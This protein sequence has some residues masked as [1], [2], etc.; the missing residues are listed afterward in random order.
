MLFSEH[1]HGF[2][3]GS[4]QNNRLWDLWV[5]CPCCGWVSRPGDTFTPGLGTASGIDAMTLP[6][7]DSVVTFSSSYGPSADILNHGSA[8]VLFDSLNADPNTAARR[9]ESR[10]PAF[11]AL[12]WSAMARSDLGA[13]GLLDTPLTSDVS[14]SLEH[15]DNPPR[16]AADSQNS[17]IL[18]D[19]LHQ[20][21]VPSGLNLASP[22]QD[23]A[24]SELDA[25]DGI[26]CTLGCGTEFT[27]YGNRERHERTACPN[28]PRGLA[29]S[30]TCGT[31]GYESS[32][33]DS[34]LRHNR[35]TGHA[36]VVANSL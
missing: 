16:T 24:D 2:S 5:R 3:S 10:P 17:A 23:D 36:A 22:T 25:S 29:Q 31:C 26:R 14:G 35:V 1:A 18:Q 33:R 9:D 19:L 4:T 30:W 7:P 20:W 28:A 11:D 12:S 34:L 15:A 21:D 27:L 8:R 32:R 13:V 6:L